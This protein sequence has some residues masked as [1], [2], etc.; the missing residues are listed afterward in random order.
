MSN[1]FYAIEI[2]NIQLDDFS[3]DTKYIEIEEILQ[4]IPDALVDTEYNLFN[5]ACNYIEK[6]SH[7]I[8]SCEEA[9]ISQVYKKIYI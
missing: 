6:F 1:H 9:K 3:F 5:S 2:K 7:G 8:L 4:Y